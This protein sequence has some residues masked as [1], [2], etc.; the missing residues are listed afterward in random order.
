MNLLIGIFGITLSI[1]LIKYRE[2]VY[3]F[4][5]KIDWAENYLGSGGTLSFLLLLGVFGFFISLTIMVGGG[6][7]FFGKFFQTFFGL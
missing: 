6:D 4:I 5:G 3:R 7:L 1:G 2:P